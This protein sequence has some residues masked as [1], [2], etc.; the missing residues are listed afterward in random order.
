MFTLVIEAGAGASLGFSTI[1]LE[2]YCLLGSIH[3]NP[4][5]WFTSRTVRLGKCVGVSV[6]VGMPVFVIV[7]VSVIVALG[8]FVG[9]LVGVGDPVTVL[10]AVPVSVAVG[11]LVLATVVLAVAVGVDVAVDDKV[12]V[13]VCVTVGTSVFVTVADAVV[14]GESVAVA[15]GAP[16]LVMVGVSTGVFVRVPVKVPV[17]VI[18]G[19]GVIVGV[20]TVVGV[21][22]G[23]HEQ[24]LSV[25]AAKPMLSSSLLSAIVP[26]KSTVTLI[27][28]LWQTAFSSASL[29]TTTSNVSPGASAGVSTRYCFAHMFTLVIEAGAGASLGFSTILLEIYCLL[30][31]I[32][33]NPSGWFT[34]RTVR[35]G[36]CVG[37]SVAVGM[38][39]FVIVTVSVIVALGEFVGVL[40]GVGDPVTVLV[41]VPVSVAVGTLVLATVVLAVAVG[42]DVAVDDKVVVPV[43]V[44]VGTSVFVTVADAVVVGESVA[45]AVGAPVLVMVGVGVIVGVSTVVG[46]GDG[47][48]E[49]RLSV[50]AAKPMLSS[51]LLSAIVPSKSTVTLIVYL[52]QTA[53]SSASLCTTTSNVSPG[54]SAGVSTRYCFAHMF[55]LVIEAGA[56]ASLGFSTILLEIYC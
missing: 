37:V 45:V 2:I 34:S 25:Y 7:T 15:V 33:V 41:A 16:V 26:S 35:L 20:S 46:V 1:L 24:R 42:V 3:V 30:G 48:H 38:P 19:V 9:V 54:A 40:V 56:G 49:Q 4:S 52:W 14:V 5:G 6:A 11:T 22:D 12:V 21:G 13:P 39:V 18:V 36:K 29:C 50:Y 53:F 23:R 27:V 28:Y 47:R 8:E 43:C 51:S 10:V 32:H 55:T 17:A 31:S 44:T